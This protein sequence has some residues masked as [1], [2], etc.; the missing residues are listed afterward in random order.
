MNSRRAVGVNRVLSYLIYNDSVFNGIQEVTGSI[1]VSSTVFFAFL[2][3]L[4]GWL[5]GG[6]S[7]QR[8]ERMYSSVGARLDGPNKQW[9]EV[10]PK[11]GDLLCQEFAA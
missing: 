8:S 9:A 2:Q 7:N 5:Q 10:A 4:G 11:L 6:C 3:P 1:P